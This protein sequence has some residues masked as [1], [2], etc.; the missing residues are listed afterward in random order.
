MFE[1]ATHL[2]TVAGVRFFEHPIYGDESPLLAS[3][4]G[5]MIHTDF[6]ERPEAD[7][8]IEFL[9]EAKA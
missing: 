8:V 3:V 5:D 6:W 1:S 7:E 2:F 9:S 4:N